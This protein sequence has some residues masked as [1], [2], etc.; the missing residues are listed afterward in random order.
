MVDTL[1]QI[2]LGTSDVCN[3]TQ[4]D[5]GI[6]LSGET[7]KHAS[8]AR[9]YGISDKYREHLQAGCSQLLRQD[10]VPVHQDA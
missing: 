7:S 10:H 2:A 8:G 5:I 4:F 9:S 1:Q 6:A 3:E